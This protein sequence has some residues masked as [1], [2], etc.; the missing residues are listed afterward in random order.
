MTLEELCV[1]EYKNAK[2]LRDSFERSGMQESAEMW[3]LVVARLGRVLEDAG[4]C[5]E[6]GVA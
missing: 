3:G 1:F 5:V 4:V 2:H 6:G